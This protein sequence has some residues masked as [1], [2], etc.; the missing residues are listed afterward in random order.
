MGEILA[1]MAF[2]LAMTIVV[3]VVLSVVLFGMRGRR[4]LAIVVLAQVVTNP[5]VEFVCLVSCWYPSLPLLSWPWA[6]LLVIEVLATVAEALLYCATSIT[7]YPWCM[8]CI[9]NATSFAV[10]LLIA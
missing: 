8:S 5:I 2:A 3:E 6:A 4:E 10:G 7:P 9:L 1:P